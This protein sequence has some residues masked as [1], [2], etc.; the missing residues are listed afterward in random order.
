[1]KKRIFLVC[2]VIAVLVISLG[3][4]AFA[5]KV[6]FPEPPRNSDVPA[7][8]IWDSETGGYINGDYK[9]DPKTNTYNNIKNVPGENDVEVLAVDW[10]KSHE[11]STKP[12]D[13]A[14]IKWYKYSLT[15]NYDIYRSDINNYAKY[16]G[17]KDI[18]NEIGITNLPEM[19][20]MVNDSLWG[21]FMIQGVQ[22]LMNTKK[23][24]RVGQS[25][26]ER[27]AWLKT[28]KNKLSELKTKGIKYEEVGNLG[29]FS[30]PYILDSLNSKDQNAS[31]IL[32]GLLDK[33][34][35]MEYNSLK[36]KDANWWKTWSDKHS[37]D[38]KSVKKFVVAYSN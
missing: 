17:F 19:I 18:I 36:T 10:V 2:S 15:L 13:I 38:L 21:E 33:Y 28:L 32:S 25:K 31:E 12:L 9:L 20:N 29:M 3:V 30:V 37:T 35:G 16:D 26:P 7:D 11:N 22:Y 8:A 4:Y 5:D 24:E 1:M 34:D 14:L 27:E 6:F 23:I